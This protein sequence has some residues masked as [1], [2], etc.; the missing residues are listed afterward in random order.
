MATTPNVRRPALP[1]HPKP[2]AQRALTVV[3]TRV[4]DRALFGVPLTSV[5]HPTRSVVASAPNAANRFAAP[6]AVRTPGAACAGT[7]CRTETPSTR[8]GP[9]PQLPRRRTQLANGREPIGQE[10]AGAVN[11]SAHPKPSAQRGQSRADTGCRTETSSTRPVRHPAPEKRPRTR[12]PTRRHADGERR[13][14]RQW[15]VEP[16]RFGAQPRDVLEVAR[17]TEDTTAAGPISTTGHSVRRLKLPPPRH[18][19]SA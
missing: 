1:R 18:P 6:R 8:L 19:H 16:H 7:G 5:R 9:A 4:P 12:L 14:G 15:A 11:R 10:F 3:R 13:T 2:S 17:P